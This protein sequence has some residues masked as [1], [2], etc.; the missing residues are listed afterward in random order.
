MA[1]EQARGEIDDLDER[2][3][4]FALGAILCE[5]LTGRPPFAGARAEVLRQ[6]REGNL[7]D[8]FARLDVCGADAELIAIAKRCLDP[9]REARFRDASQ[10]ARELGSH[11]ASVDERRRTAELEAAEARA[12]AAGERRIRWLTMA[13]AGVIVLSLLAGGSLAFQ[14]ERHRARAALEHAQAATQRARAEAERSRADAERG[15]QLEA[16]LALVGTLRPKGL[17][18]MDQ[19]RH[20]PDSDAAKWAEAI[21]LTRQAVERTGLLAT[22]EPTRQSRQEILA[23]LRRFETELRQRAERAAAAPR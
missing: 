14:S 12:R 16:A 5:I 13:L 10:V 21:A 11:L 3:D 17:W 9:A 15:R 1:P 7:A 2:C 4:V 19:A 22:D 8:S 18:V 20:A 6:A 23:E